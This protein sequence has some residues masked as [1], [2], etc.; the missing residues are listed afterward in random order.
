MHSSIALYIGLCIVLYIGLKSPMV[1]N[2]SNV[3]KIE[4]QGMMNRYRIE[5]CIVFSLRYISYKTKPPPS[6]DRQP[7]RNTKKF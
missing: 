2:L 7:H 1:R 6:L 5:G 3:Y 4:D